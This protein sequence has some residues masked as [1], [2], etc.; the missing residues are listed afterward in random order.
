MQI[1]FKSKEGSYE[2]EVAATQLAVLFVWND[3]RDDRF[4][5]DAIR[6]RTQLHDSELR[7]TLLVRLLILY[8]NSLPHSTFNLESNFVL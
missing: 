5:L 3:A 6:L 1:Q 8:N 2:L 7:K 4:S